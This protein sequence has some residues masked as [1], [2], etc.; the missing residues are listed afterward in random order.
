MDKRVRNVTALGLLTIVAV[1][2]GIWGVYFLMG[3][4]F[5]KNNLEVALVLENGAGLKR[6]DRVL[7]QGVQVGTVRSVD[8][9]PAA[10]VVV[11]TRLRSDLSLPADTRAT[12]MGDVFGAHTVDLYPG[13]A[14]VRLERGDT[15]RGTASPQLTDLAADLSMRAQ[16]V[17]T[18]AD[19][20]LSPRALADVHAT[21]AVLPATAQ[22]LRAAFQE[23][24]LAAAALKRTAEELETAGAGATVVAAVDEMVGEMKESARALTT[25]A[26]SM[27]RSLDTFSSVLGKIDNGEGTLGR[28]VNDP[29]LYNE[30]H[31]TLREVGALA[32][33]IRERPRRYIS[34]R[35]F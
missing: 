25:A 29:S 31:Q 6:G 22:E 10:E 17:L 14:L 28:L 9:S 12:V 27:G 35:L 11:V 23:F 1:V 2:V 34:L 30:F 32:T 16:S 4:P 3:T 21:V 7:V 15:I 8:L 13:R 33:D 24:R 5:W 26:S 18:A 19:S 20:L